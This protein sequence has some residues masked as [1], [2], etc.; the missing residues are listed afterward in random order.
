M[1]KQLG[2]L[3]LPLLCL[4]YEDLVGYEGNET[5]EVMGATATA[6]CE[7]LEVEVMPLI[8]YT[9]RVNPQP[10]CELVENWTELAAALGGTELGRIL[11]GEG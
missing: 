5:D 3:G 2:R 7:H 11:E 4:T 8:S 10:L 9:R 6:I 1:K